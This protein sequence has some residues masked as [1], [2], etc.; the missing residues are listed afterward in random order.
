M[1]LL[2]PIVPRLT[3]VQEE[4][5]GKECI[6]HSQVTH[7]FYD[8][9]EG[10]NVATAELQS[11]APPAKTQELQGGNDIGSGVHVVRSGGPLQPPNR[12]KV[13]NY[14]EDTMSA[15]SLP[16]KASS[17]NRHRPSD[18]DTPETPAPQ[19]RRCRGRGNQ[20]GRGH[21]EGQ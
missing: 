21:H 15:P 16:S 3:I 20:A 10:L 8:L 12:I 11:L 7:T 5:E 17:V 4:L 1:E 6:T 14:G 18:K 2:E 19:T 9:R 13:L